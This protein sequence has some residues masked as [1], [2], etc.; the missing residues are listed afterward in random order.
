MKTVRVYCHGPIAVSR[1][2]KVGWEDVWLS[3]SGKPGRKK[4]RAAPT[5]MG[6]RDLRGDIEMEESLLA[7][8]RYAGE[9]W[10]DEISAWL[11]KLKAARAALNE[12]RGYVFLNA[13]DKNSANHSVYVSGEWLDRARAE[14]AMRAYLATVHGLKAVR[15]QWDRPKHVVYPVTLGGGA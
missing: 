4:Y 9:P 11:S 12:G 5:L 6:E 10:L 3:W 14:D 7:D 15:F 13:A 1:D 8:P 2:A